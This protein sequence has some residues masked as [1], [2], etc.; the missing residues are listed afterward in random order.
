MT[1][2]QS[3]GRWD[4][5]IAAGLVIV[6]VDLEDDDEEKGEENKEEETR[7][8]GRRRRRRRKGMDEV[9][10]KSVMPSPHSYIT[11]P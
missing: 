9:L 11:L 10:R 5:V 6:L 3:V 1:S 8:K 7:L 2:I 4:R